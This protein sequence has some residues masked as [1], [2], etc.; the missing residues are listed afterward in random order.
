MFDNGRRGLCLVMPR[1]I[2]DKEWVEEVEWIIK[3]GADFEIKKAMSVFGDEGRRYIE[4]ISVPVSPSDQYKVSLADRESMDDSNLI[5]W[6]VC[7]IPNGDMHETENVN[8]CYTRTLV[9]RLFIEYLHK[10][11]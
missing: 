5:E 6:P 11:G 7:G 10:H 3:G 2:M 1:T 4:S 9:I 8:S